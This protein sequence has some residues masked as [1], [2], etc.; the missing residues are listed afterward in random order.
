MVDSETPL[1]TEQRLERH[2]EAGEWQDETL[3]DHFEAAL[4]RDPDAEAVVDPRLRLTYAEVDDRSDRLAT[5]L[6]AAGLKEGDVVTVQLPNW[7]EWLV[8]RLGLMKLGAAINP[9]PVNLRAGDLEYIVDLIDPSAYVIPDT[10]RDFDFVSMLRDRLTYDD[11]VVTLS[12]RPSETTDREST[13]DL[14]ELMEP[15]GDT[16]FPGQD[17]NAVSELPFTSGTTGDPKGCMMSQNT[18]NAAVGAYN[19]RAE[20]GSDAVLLTAMPVGHQGGYG[21]GVYPAI[22]SGGTCVF[23]PTADWSGERGARV[24]DDK[25][26]THIWAPTPFLHD[27]VHADALAERDTSSLELFAVGGASVSETLLETANRRL[28]ADV[29]GSYGQTEDALATMTFPDDPAA[30]KTK[31]DGYPLGGMEFKTV[32]PGGEFPGDTGRLLLR[33]PFLMLGFYRKSEQ[34]LEAMEGGADGWYRTGDLGRIDEDGYVTITGREKFVI[35]R[36]GEQVPVK[37]VEE[38]LHCHEAVETA[39]IVAMPDDRLQEKACAYVST[40]DGADFD[41]DEMIEYLKANDLTTQYL[42]E[43]LELIDEFPRSVSGN[44]ERHELRKD[45]AEKLGMEPVMR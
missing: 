23:L 37:K 20:I 28:E 21:Y 25:G 16:S 2:R 30:K 36:G 33:G 4:D 11:L 9:I 10:N 15:A 43:R 14:G 1:L 32:D 13:T 6:R 35:M 41:F 40:V 27:L 44:I 34:T 3:L 38:L 45:I 18:L 22:R 7:S 5:G 29:V 31:T 12:A 42:P 8:V 26:I 24:I 19:E 17:P 39:A